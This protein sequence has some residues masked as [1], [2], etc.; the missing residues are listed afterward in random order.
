MK[1]SNIKT[2]LK[3]IVVGYIAYLAYSLPKKDWQ[4]GTMLT[5]EDN[6][7]VKKYYPNQCLY[8]QYMGAWWLD[9]I[10]EGKFSQIIDEYVLAKIGIKFED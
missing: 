6:G 9:V 4:A 1:K 5:T 10:N 8:V 7:K 2:L 3:Y